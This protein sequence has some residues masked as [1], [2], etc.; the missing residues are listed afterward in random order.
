[1]IMSLARVRHSLGRRHHLPSSSAA[2]SSRSAGGVIQYTLTRRVIAEA[3]AGWLPAERGPTSKRSRLESGLGGTGD[4]RCGL[5]AC[6]TK[7]VLPRGGLRHGKAKR[8]GAAPAAAVEVALEGG[9]AARAAQPARREG[10]AWLQST[11]TL[12]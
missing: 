5:Q 6:R 9:A 8:L 1:M 2:A 10:R 11:T 3:G 12:P 7:A 4:P